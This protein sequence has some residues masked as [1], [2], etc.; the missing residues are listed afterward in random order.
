MIEYG[1]YRIA[2]P[3]SLE[4]PAMV[5]FESALDHNIATMCERAGGAQNLMV[6]VK[7]HK[8]DAVTRK[9]IDAGVCGFKCATVKEVEMVLG[10]GA[11]AGERIGDNQRMH[12]VRP[13]PS[14][15]LISTGPA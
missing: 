2:D 7:T 12:H 8:S 11:R 5:V 3:D 13:V 10:A 1:D 4:T 6:H 9:Q 15:R 14:A